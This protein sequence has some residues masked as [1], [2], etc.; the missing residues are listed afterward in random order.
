MHRHE[1]SARSGL[2]EGELLGRLGRGVFGLG[3]LNKSTV[4]VTVTVI[5]SLSSSR[6]S[7]R[8]R[9]PTRTRTT[10]ADA[11]KGRAPAVGVRTGLFCLN[12]FTSPSPSP[13]LPQG[14]L[15]LKSLSSSRVSLPL[16]GLNL[17]NANIWKRSFQPLEA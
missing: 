16:L 9:L 13:S 12:K 1:K 8:R 10:G 5:K 4:T 15:F 2:A 6:V 3:N 11:G 17:L 14:S 7:P